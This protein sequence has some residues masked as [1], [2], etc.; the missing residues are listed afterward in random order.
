MEASGDL[1]LGASLTL[2]E[3]PKDESRVKS[4]SMLFWARGRLPPLVAIEERTL[5]QGETTFLD[6]CCDGAVDLRIN[7]WGHIDFI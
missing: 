7:E 5:W 4:V 6:A 3:R 2:P 1:A